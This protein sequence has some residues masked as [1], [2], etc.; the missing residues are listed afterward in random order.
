MLQIIAGKFKGRKL[1]APPSTTTRPTQGVLREALFNICQNYIEEA[2]FL[3][4]FAGSGAVGFEALSR[5]AEYVAFVEKEKK[6]VQAIQENISLLKVE[7]QCRVFPFSAE[8]ALKKLSPLTFDLVYIDPP[9]DREIG[10]YI[11]SLLDLH[12]V[13]PHGRI[14]IEERFDPKKPIKVLERSSLKRI[15]SRRFG[16]ALLHHYS[17]LN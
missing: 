11:D 5:G 3:D 4:L 2:R 7:N 14:F 6:A 15:D 8:N 13:A 1:K 12:L 17:R 9:Y 10:L 16:I